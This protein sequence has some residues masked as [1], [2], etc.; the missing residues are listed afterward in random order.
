MSKMNRSSLAKTFI[1]VSLILLTGLACEQKNP[2]DSTQSILGNQPNLVNMRAE[3]GQISAPGGISV[4]RVTLLDQND[5]PM[6]SAVVQFA[7]TG[8]GRLDTTAASTDSKGIAKVNYYSGTRA[9]DIRITALYANSNK[10][11]PIKVISASSGQAMLLVTSSRSTLYANGLDTSLVTVQMIPDSGMT[12]GGTLINLSTSF[13]SLPFNVMI[14]PDGFATAVLRSDTSFTDTEAMVTASYNSMEAVTAVP[15]KAVS[16]SIESDQI[17]LP[18][19]GKSTCKITAT[20]KQ[21][22]SGKPINKAPVEFFTDVGD[23]QNEILTESSGKAT[24]TLT[25]SP[26]PD[27]T[28]VKAWYGDLQDSVR[29]IFYS[30]NI[31]DDRSRIA[32]LTTAKTEIWANP[33][34]QDAIT[35]RVVDQAG[36]PKENAT[37]YL[38]SSAGM[39]S[40]T[41]VLTNALGEAVVYLTGYES[42]FDSTATVKADLY[43]GTPSATVSVL[44]KSESYKPRFIEIKFDPPSIGVIETGQI[45]TTTVLASVKD[46]KY[47]LVGDNIRVFFDLIEQ[48]GGVK[49]TAVTDQGVPTV[50]GVAKISC[51]AGIRSGTVRMRARLV[52]DPLTEENEAEIVVESTKLIIHAG[53]PFMADRNDPATSHLS[54]TSFRKNIWYGQDTTAVTVIIGDKYKNPVDRKTAIYLTASGGVITTESFTDLNGI[55]NDTLFAGSP[56]PT[57]ARYHGFD[58]HLYDRN[59]EYFITGGAAP[60]F[61]GDIPP[62]NYGGDYMWNPN[63]DAGNNMFNVI[64]H[65]YG[66]SPDME[67]GEVPNSNTLDFINPNA[68]QTGENDGVCRIVASTIGVD[69]NGDSIYVWNWNHVIFSTEILDNVVTLAG[70]PIDGFRENSALVSQLREVQLQPQIL[71]IIAQVRTQHPNVPAGMSNLDL[72]NQFLPNGCGSVLFIGEAARVTF[73]IFDVHGN[74]I[75]SGSRLTTSLT[76]KPPMALSW[77]ELTTGNGLGTTTYDIEIANTVDIEKPKTGASAVKLEVNYSGDRKQLNTITFRAEDNTVEGYIQNKF[78][79]YY[80]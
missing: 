54:I 55:I 5:K 32:S 22:S 80:P 6:P 35:V 23:I 11:V 69:A 16:F 60:V 62:V 7:L 79:F 24:V 38:E 78:Y 41:Q 33:T 73:T 42:D 39:L 68:W 20:V 17:S 65:I 19:D 71:Q 4:I 72:Y 49:V 75:H 70:I 61:L 58:L 76:G 10:S 47:R 67:G 31:V 44:L 12:V 64:Q 50:Q 43:N 29:I 15:V 13:G 59:Y 34:Y 30:N 40:N 57:V 2:L 66:P 21:K 45:S 48:P 27:T 25:S 9:A 53:P 56:S 63:Y 14:G 37:V 46:A 51:T 74:P 77:T 18:A 1:P 3:P 28:V 36:A 52:D 8:D 26:T